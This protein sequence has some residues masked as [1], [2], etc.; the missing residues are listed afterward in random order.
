M[1]RVRFAVVCASNQ[2]RSMEAHHVLRQNN[3]D[4]S[5][6]GTGTSVRLPGPSADKPNIYPFG[7]PYDDIYNELA[8]QDRNLYTQNGLLQMLDRNRRIKQAPER[9]QES[10]AVFDVVFTC[11]ERC[12]DAAC[13]GQLEIRLAI[14]ILCVSLRFCKLSS[15]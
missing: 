4:I 11:E 10:T 9:F 13:D 8:G 15:T 5:S 14:Q 2:N 6:F 7:T 12:F 3:F 1:P